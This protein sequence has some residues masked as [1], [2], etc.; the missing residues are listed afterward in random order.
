MPNG[1]ELQICTKKKRLFFSAILKPFLKFFHQNRKHS[2]IFFTVPKTVFSQSIRMHTIICHNLSWHCTV[3]SL[4]PDFSSDS[5]DST[6]TVWLLLSDGYGPRTGPD[7]LVEQSC[8]HNDTGYGVGC[9][10]DVPDAELITK[11]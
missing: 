11:I 2:C 6:L 5:V 4:C 3:P 7:H 9:D 1:M 8:H 10:L